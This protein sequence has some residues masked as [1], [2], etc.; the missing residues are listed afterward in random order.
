MKNT[1]WLIWSIEHSAWWC[2]KSKGYTIY[3]PDAGVYTYDEALKI[4]KGA[5]Y[6]LTLPRQKKYDK[7]LNTPQEAMVLL[8]EEL[9]K[10]ICNKKK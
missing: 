1:L 4:V 6:C 8:T 2:A 9:S 10:Q 3:F 7:W 5:N